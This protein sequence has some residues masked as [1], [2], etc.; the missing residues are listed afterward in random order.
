MSAKLI[1]RLSDFLDSHQNNV[2]WNTCIFAVVPAIPFRIEDCDE[3]EQYTFCGHRQ[4]CY[5][6]NDPKLFCQHYKKHCC[7]LCQLI[8]KNENDF[9]NQ[10]ISKSWRYYT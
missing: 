1:A 7:N 9:K 6:T 3:T 4:R 10:K 2:A 5:Y 8:A